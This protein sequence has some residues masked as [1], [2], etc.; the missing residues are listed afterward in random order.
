MFGRSVAEMV[1]FDASELYADSRD[2]N[3]ILQ[4]VRENGSV[5]DH[6]VALRRHDGSTF[7]AL[8][9]LSP[10]T[11]HN[12]PSFFA[13]IHDISNLKQAQQQQSELEREL[14]QAQKLEAVG[15]L[16][17]GIAHEI[18]TP[19]QYVWDNLKFLYDCHTELRPLIEQS[20][21]LIARI[22]TDGPL[23]AARDKILEQKQRLDVDYLLTEIPAAIDQSISRSVDQGYHRHFVYR[24]G[25]ERVF[26]SRW[27][28]PE[29]G[30][31][32]QPHAG[33]HPDH[34]T[35]RM[36]ASGPNGNAAGPCAARCQV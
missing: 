9:S 7:P 11:Y 26:P 6:E 8:I 36:E 35:Q 30:R 24:Q 27:Q 28:R 17:G 25:H 19:S 10:T 21:A 14:H 29:I 34:F 18:N 15:Q 5:T 23:Q 16:A 22:D 31:G 12:E 20:L 33:E 1:G 4:M 3:V 2:R 13:W 32:H